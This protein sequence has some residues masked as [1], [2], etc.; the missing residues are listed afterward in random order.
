M[1]QLRRSHSGRRAAG[2]TLVE[3]LLS[4]MLT[5]M[6]G[7]AVAGMLITVTYGSDTAQDVRSGVILHKTLSE[8]VNASVRGSTT[9][10]DVCPTHLVLWISDTRADDQ[11][12][13]SELRRIEYDSI[14]EELRSYSVDWPAG[15]TQVQIDAADVAYPLGSDFDTVTEALTAQAYFPVTVWARDLTAGTFAI[16]HVDAQS[17]TLVSYRF[18]ATIGPTVGTI[19]GAASPRSE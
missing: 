5:G 9:I 17:A 2:L 3:L 8:R 19:I 1:T 10:L 12:N 13:V 7:A 18:S 16:N 6:I 4:V 15:W 11:P 14:S